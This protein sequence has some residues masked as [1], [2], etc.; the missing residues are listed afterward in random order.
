[1]SPK[2][3]RKREK[4]WPKRKKETQKKGKGPDR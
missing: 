1:M 3:K 4:T 2:G